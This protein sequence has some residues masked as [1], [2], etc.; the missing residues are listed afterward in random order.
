VVSGAGDR[1]RGRARRVGAG[2][3][4]GVTGTA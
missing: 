4:A 2:T 3:A 1:R